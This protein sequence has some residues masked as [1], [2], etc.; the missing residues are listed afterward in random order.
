MS[1]GEHEPRCENFVYTIKERGG[2][3]M[4]KTAEEIL[5]YLIELLE[6]Y[7]WEIND[8]DGD[9]FIGE[10]YAYIECLEIIQKWEKASEA[11]LDYNIE[12]RFPVTP[13]LRRAAPSQRRNRIK[14]DC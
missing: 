4:N 11:G 3:E 6:Y 12:K 10:K 8:L 13:R 7:L 1:G 5:K 2:S 9:F 14:K